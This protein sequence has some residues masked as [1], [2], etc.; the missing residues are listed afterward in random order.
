MFRSP[1]SLAASVAISGALFAAPASAAILTYFGTLGPEVS[2]ATGTGTTTI[3][4]DTVADTMRVQV[5]FSGLSG[6]TS[7]AHIHCC[8]PNPLTGTAGVA[9]QVPSFTGFPTGVKAGSYDQTFNTA[10]AATWNAP[11]ITNNGGTPGSA[12]NALIAG[13]DAG[14]AYLNM[15]STSFPGG[16]IRAFARRVP[17]P[18]T[19]ALALLGVAGL[20][21]TANRR[22]KRA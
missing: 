22:R 18:A 2:G 4:F 1:R 21:F 17:E 16:E 14:R 13:F 5:T 9:T 6:N 3:T 12:R 19:L 7:V 10:L 20:G 11:F 15:H 8:T